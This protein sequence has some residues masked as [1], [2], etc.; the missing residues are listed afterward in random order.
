MNKCTENDQLFDK[1]EILI[2]ISK[3]PVDYKKH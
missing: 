2:R 1:G 3:K